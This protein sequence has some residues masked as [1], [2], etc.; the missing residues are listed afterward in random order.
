[1]AVV[2][3]GSEP[4]GG[5]RRGRL[6]SAHAPRSTCQQTSAHENGT[7]RTWR[8]LRAGAGVCRGRCARRRPG[9]LRG[10][11]LD[12]GGRCG[13]WRRVGHRHPRPLPRQGHV[14]SAAG[15]ALGVPPGGRGG[16]GGGGGTRRGCFRRHT[17]APALYAGGRLAVARAAV[18][19]RCRSRRR[20]RPSPFER[21]VGRCVP[22][23]DSA[24]RLQEPAGL[25][26]L[27]LR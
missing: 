6:R 3:W 1:M 9:A 11:P 8:G 20:R 18:T 7:R 24:S 10:I 23:V 16:S 25:F 21:P 26:P 17:H 27:R 15:D 22:L 13:G 14:R 19:R 5:G 4:R 2:A 12:R